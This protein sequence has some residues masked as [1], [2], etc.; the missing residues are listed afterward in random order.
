MVGV[1]GNVLSAWAVIL[2][3]SLLVFMKILINTASFTNFCAMLWKVG[4][5]LK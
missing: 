5:V 2:N 3:F 1:N 4:V